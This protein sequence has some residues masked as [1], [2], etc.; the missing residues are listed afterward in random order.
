MTPEEQANM[1]IDS[2]GACNGY[3]DCDSCALTYYMEYP[4]ECSSDSAYEAAEDLISDLGQ[5]RCRS[6][7]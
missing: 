2:D 5:G 7:W 4:D 6:I 3:W 1:I